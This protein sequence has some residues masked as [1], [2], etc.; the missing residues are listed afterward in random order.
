LR[1]H[2]HRSRHLHLRFLSRTAHRHL[3]ETWQLF[4]ATSKQRDISN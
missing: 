3:R 2:L 1:V 4:N